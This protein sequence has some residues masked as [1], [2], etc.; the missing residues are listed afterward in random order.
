MFSIFRK[1]DK[2]I[3]PII[4]EMRE[5]LYSSDT[6]DPFLGKLEDDSRSVFP[7]SHFFDANDALR[8]GEDDKAIL[9][10]KQI[11]DADGLDTRIYLQ[12][13]RILRNL[14]VMPE[15]SLLRQIQ[16][17]V[18]EYHMKEGLDILAAF[19]DH[20]ARYWNYSGTGIVWEKPDDPDVDKL[21]DELLE[22]GQEIINQ[23]G[24]A[25]KPTP[26][27]PARGS[28][29]I[30]LMAYGG[31]CFGEGGFNELSKDAM[32]KYAIGAGYNLMTGLMKK[33][34]EIQA[35]A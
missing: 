10:L 30:F 28:V 12:A 19:S 8:K 20:S 24:I 7:W 11:T 26:S 35:K 33:Q 6:L 13:W 32:G 31:S 34:Q 15:E 16:G 27:I 21:I 25:E 2:E 29:R 5:T 1:K 23:L 3:P 17:I 4:L 14:G 18:I 9:F 22:V